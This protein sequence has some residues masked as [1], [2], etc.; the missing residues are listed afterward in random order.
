MTFLAEIGSWIS[1]NEA[2]LSGLAAMIVVGGVFLS[3][4][5]V[6]YRRFRLDRRQGDSDVEGAS[7]SVAPGSERDSGTPASEPRPVPLTFKRLTAPSSHETRFA[8]SDGVRIAYNERGSGPLDI[9]CAPGIISHLNMMDNLPSTRG[10]LDCLEEFAHVVVFD[11]RGQGL[12]DPSVA[13]PDLEQRTADI[14][15]VMDAAGVDRGILLG[16]SEG[17][18][19]CLHFTATHPDRVQGLVLLGTTA[20]WVQ[21][22]TSRS[23]LKRSLASGH[24]VNAVR[25]RMSAL[26][27]KAGRFLPLLA[28]ASGLH[29]SPCKV[30]S[31]T[32][33]TACACDRRTRTETRSGRQVPAATGR[34]LPS[35]TSRG[36]P[37]RSAGCS[38]RRSRVR[39]NVRPSP[40]RSRAGACP[41]SRVRRSEADY[42]V[43]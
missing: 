41:R 23:R 35:E 4:I 40:W 32:A 42:G 10:T 38:W 11:K 12:S 2:L 37:C 31:E 33:W 30:A 5:G 16:F 29:A 15:A 21:T 39:E 8:N 7:A 43:L 17:G 20:C 18:P 26:R 25:R 24:F 9:L 36:S 3:V 13:T 28:T 14:A 1:E 19:M 34:V 27:R 22:E 6:G